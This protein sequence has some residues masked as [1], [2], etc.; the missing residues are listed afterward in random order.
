MS[1][2]TLL[3]PE[4][5]APTRVDR[6]T[7]QRLS[8]A[9]R[10]KD[11]GCYRNALRALARLGNAT[12][13]E[14]VAVVDNGLRF[15]HAWLETANG[16][17]DP[18]PI[19]AAM[20][21]GACTY[22]AGPRWSLVEIDALFSAEQSDIETPILPFDLTDSPQRGAS[23]EA[24]LAAYR[25]VSALHLRQTGQ[26]AIAREQDE[27]TL[28]GLLGSYWAGRVLEGCT[29]WAERPGCQRLSRLHTPVG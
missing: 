16:V 5:A 19:Y 1:A 12:Y 26:P 14:G 8:H 11:R 28:C 4:L 22:F 27:A 9:I 21:E 29:G 6:A 24:K 18:T 23:I 10:A 20:E 17:V 25:H 3:D 13:V 15:E 2:L 7:S